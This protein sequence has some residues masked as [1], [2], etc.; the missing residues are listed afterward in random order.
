M[1]VEPY[2]FFDGR[3]EEALSFYRN[4]IGAETTFLMRFKDSPE[5]PQEG[6]AQPGAGDKVMHAAFKL[7][8]TLIMASDGRCEGRP[9]FQGFA[10]TISVRDE[11]EA[12][13]VFKAMSE[14]GQVQQPLTKTFFSPSFGMLADR[15]GVGWM[16]I[17][18]Q[19]EPNAP[20]K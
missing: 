11:A 3:C 15:F 19:D 10:L 1:Y 6:C 16:V 17:V 5:P 4:A 14:G 9:S 18:P 2:L 12:E 8:D 13:R 20:R 7:G